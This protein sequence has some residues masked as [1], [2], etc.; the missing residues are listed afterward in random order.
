MSLLDIP[1]RQP[2]K[3][4]TF[5]GSTLDICHHF[6]LVVQTLSNLLSSSDPWSYLLFHLLVTM[7]FDI[8][9]PGVQITG[10]LKC[11]YALKFTVAMVDTFFHHYFAGF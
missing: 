10:L 6:L 2:L 7:L 9:M 3:V 11:L 1:L 4:S 5:L 8:T